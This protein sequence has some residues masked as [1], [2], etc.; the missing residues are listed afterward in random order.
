MPR[1]RRRV[2]GLVGQDAPAAQRG[3]ARWPTPSRPTCRSC[4]ASVRERREAG[5][6]RGVRDG[7]HAGQLEVLRIRRPVPRGEGGRRVPR[8]LHVDGAART[9]GCRGLDRAV[10]LP[11]N[12]ATWK[13]G[14]ALAAGNTVVLKP[15]E[16][17]LAALRLAEITADILPSGVLNV[18][19]GRGETAGVALRRT[20]RRHGVAHRQ[21]G[22]GTGRRQRGQSN[23]QAG[24]PRAGWQGTG[25]RVRRRRHRGRGRQPHRR[26]VLQLGP[27]LHGAVPGDRRPWR[28]R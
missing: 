28:T 7:P 19:C 26:R 17:T 16:L 3:P 13:V 22:R 6:D 1:S 18:V 15:S 11:L 23:P 20:P 2:R 24:A 10:E 25:D 12:M 4:R 14:P 27:G 5:V 8:G 21:R 9:A